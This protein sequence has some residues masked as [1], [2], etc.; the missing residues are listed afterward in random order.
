MAEIKTD[1]NITGALDEDLTDGV[2][3]IT[4]SHATW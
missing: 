4:S 1:E 2:S 3:G